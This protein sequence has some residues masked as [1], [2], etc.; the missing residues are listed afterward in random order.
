MSW[1][2]FQEFAEVYLEALFDERKLKNSSGD[3]KYAL[4]EAPFQL[5]NNIIERLQP[6]PTTFKG[7]MNIHQ[8]I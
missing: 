4:P 5:D 2:P 7:S 3:S 8:R 6:G 1:P